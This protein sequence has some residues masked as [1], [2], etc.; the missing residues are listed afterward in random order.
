MANDPTPMHRGNPPERWERLGAMSGIVAAVMLV[1]NLVL[2]SSSPS[3]ASPARQVIDHLERN[4]TVTLVACYLGAVTTVLLLPFLA[5]LKTFVHGPAGEAEWRWTVTLLSGAI[6]FTVLIVGSAL[7]AAATV[8]SA[9]PVG[10]ASVAALF[11]AAK[12]CFSLAL[13][14]LA[15][16]ILTNARTMSSSRI[17]VRWLIRFGVEVGVLAI[18]SGTVVFVD[19]GWFGPGEPA[20]ALMGFLVAMWLVAVATT[21]LQGEKVAARAE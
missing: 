21:M 12:V 9:R 7:L 20:V 5:S 11:A 16:M 15:A 6:A 2:V 13:M 18:V 17:P 3:A 19:N 4:N 14:P 1:G 8:L 10:E